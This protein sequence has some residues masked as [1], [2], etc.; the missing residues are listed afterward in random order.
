MEHNLEIIRQTRRCRPEILDAAGKMAGLDIANFEALCREFIANGEDTVLGIL[1]NVC[2]VRQIKLD[3][4]L[5]G[6]VLK[7]IQPV[8]DF[9]SLYRFQGADAIP[10]LLSAAVDEAFSFE[11]QA[12]ATL[13]AAEMTVVH[14]SDRQPVKRVLQIIEQTILLRLSYGFEKSFPG[15]SIVF[16]RAYM[17]GNP[18][19]FFD[20]EVLINV[21]RR[22]RAEI[23]MEAWDD[24]VEDYLEWCYQR[25]LEESEEKKMSQALHALNDKLTNAKENIRKGQRELENKENQP[26]SLMDKR[27]EAQYK[28]E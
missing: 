20:N 11:C 26:L 7:V 27:C 16:A 15:L 19:H 2:A 6:D 14:G 21:V 4:D 13:L 12:Y 3:P 17:A 22:A 28:R 1:M 8:S 18:D 9:G 25:D 10:A 5:L 23:D 24:L